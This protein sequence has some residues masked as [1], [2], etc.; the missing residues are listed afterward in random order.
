M[1][2]KTTQNPIQYLTGQKSKKP[3]P[4]TCLNMRRSSNALTDVYDRYLASCSVTVSQYS[5]LRHIIYLA[6]VSVSDLSV[7]LRLDRTTLVRNLRPLEQKKW[8]EDIAEE[9]TR[10]RQLQLTELG[11]QVF[12]CADERWEQAQA[13]ITKHLGDEDAA[14]LAELLEKIEQYQGR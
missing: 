12:A 6:P 1:A 2:D 7:A 13:D 3:S 5:I 10:N 8:I 11:R 9:G 14:K 4:C